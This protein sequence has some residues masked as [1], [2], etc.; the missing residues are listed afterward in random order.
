MNAAAAAV[1]RSLPERISPEIGW[2]TGLL[3][4]LVCIELKYASRDPE[5][6]PGKQWPAVV[7]M[8]SWLLMYPD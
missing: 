5:S 7:V 4:Q 6:E 2:N 3:A 1:T 8:K